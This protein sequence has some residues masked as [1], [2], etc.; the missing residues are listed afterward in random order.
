LAH[1]ILIN[2][3]M[4]LKKPS[5]YHAI[6]DVIQVFSKLSLLYCLLL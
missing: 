6:I 4:K 3:G 2:L 1:E 5:L